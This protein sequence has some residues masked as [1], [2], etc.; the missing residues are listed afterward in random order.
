MLYFIFCFLFIVFYSSCY[1]R[2]LFCSYFYCRVLFYLLSFFII[3]HVFI[4]CILFIVFF[5]FVFYLSFFSFLSIGPKTHFF[6]L[7]FDPNRPR[8]RPTAA[9]QQPRPQWAQQQQAQLPGARQAQACWPGPLP[10]STWAPQVLF[11]CY[12]TWP[13]FP[14]LATVDVIPNLVVAVCSNTWSARQAHAEGLLLFLFFPHGQGPQACWP[15]LLSLLARKPRPCCLPFY[16]S[17][18]LKCSLLQ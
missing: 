17:F 12:F 15:F 7:K 2:V 9:G 4:C 1:F 16:F 6:G 5:I 8:M 18:P 13:S 11:L 3:Y 14:F 10:L